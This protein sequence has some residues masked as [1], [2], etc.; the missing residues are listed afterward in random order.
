MRSQTEQFRYLWWP[1]GRTDTQPQ[2]LTFSRFPDSPND[3]TRT[4]KVVLSSIKSVS[5]IVSPNDKVPIVESCTKVQRQ[6]I[7]KHLGYGKSAGGNAVK[8]RNDRNAW[9]TLNV[10]VVL[11]HEIDTDS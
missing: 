5:E 11:I 4:E 6:I 9:G 2:F 8:I 3:C 10:V 7:K 1:P